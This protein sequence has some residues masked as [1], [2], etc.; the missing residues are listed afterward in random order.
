NAGYY[1]GVFDGRYV[2]FVPYNNGSYHGDVLRYDTQGAFNATGSWAHYDA[3]YN[4]GYA[5]GVFDGRYVYFVPYYNGSYHGDVLRY[6]TQGAFN[7]I[8]S[9]SHYDAGYNAGYHGGVFDGRY[10]YFVPFKNGSHHGDVLRY[11]TQGAFNATGSWSHYDAG[12][13]DGYEGGVFDGRYVYFV[14]YYNGSYHG[15]VLRYDT[16]GAF[17]ATGSWSHYDTGYNAGYHGG[18]F[19][20]RYVYFV[21]FNNGSYHGDVLRYDTQGAFD[22]I[23]SWSHYDT[24]YNAGYHGGVFDGSH[25]YFVPFGN[26][27]HGDVL[28]YDTAGA[29]SSF[30]LSYNAQNQSGG[31]AGAPWGVTFQF[32]SGNTT[33]TLASN[34]ALD[35]AA[36][37]HIA[38]VRNDS[39]I[40]LYID[41]VV[42]STLTG[43]SGSINLSNYDLSVGAYPGAISG[44]DGYIDELRVSKGIARWSS[45]FSASLPSAPYLAVKEDM[46]LTSISKTASATTT[47]ARLIVFEEDVDAITVNTDLKAYV[48]NN[49]GSNFYEVTLSE[50][51]N[52]QS[53]KRVLSGTVDFG[54][55][56]TDMKWRLTTHNNKEC[57]IY[58]IGY[59]WR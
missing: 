37:H 48:S 34:S 32:A 52:Y 24:G 16:Q 28:R 25:I 26:G 39:T 3:G 42:K 35:N 41:G 56:G 10:V 43:V 2:Y 19:D 20:G 49:G 29:N 7:A 6:D 21:P 5:G 47:N 44:Y 50:D 31:F 15:D 14:P 9:W 46:T 58:G 59:T 17:N 54:T 18:L 53:G 38:V 4:D 45:D 8:G 51:G 27:T 23:G 1:G 22:A 33:Y 11:D 40:T 55:S 12:Y 30:K 57:R 36:F 13:N